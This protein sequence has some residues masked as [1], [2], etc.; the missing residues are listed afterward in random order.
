MGFVSIL[1]ENEGVSNWKNLRNITEE[2]RIR[3][4]IGSIFQ[5]NRKFSLEARLVTYMNITMTPPIKIKKKIKAYQ[6][7]G[8]IMKFNKQIRNVITTIAPAKEI[9]WEQ[10][11]VVVA[12]TNIKVIFKKIIT[13]QGVVLK[14]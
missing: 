7:V 11:M 9:G 1:D 6:E 3:V 8:K 2:I 4:V 14:Y 13:I 5:S 10:N 12:I